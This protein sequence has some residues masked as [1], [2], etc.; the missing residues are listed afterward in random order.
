MSAQH[1]PGPWKLET[2][3]HGHLVNG[4]DGR[5]VVYLHRSG[6][7]NRAEIEANARLVAA[8]PELL[9]AL[10]AARNALEHAACGQFGI[11]FKSSLDVTRDAIAKAE[12]TE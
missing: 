4:A 6:V 11:D 8:A 5:T 1:T 9:E 7:R 12:G 2:E 10:H 3:G